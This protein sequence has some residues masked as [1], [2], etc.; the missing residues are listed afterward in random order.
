MEGGL[1]AP[2]LSREAPLTARSLVGTIVVT[3]AATRSV[4]KQIGRAHV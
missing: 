1:P 3:A 4:W 2:S